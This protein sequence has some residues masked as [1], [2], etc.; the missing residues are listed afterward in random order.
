M[1]TRALAARDDALQ[2]YADE[3][4]MLTMLAGEI[5][6]ELKNPLASV[7]GLTGLL[8]KDAAG[9]RA[10]WVGVMR[11]EIER[12]QSILEEFLNFS[13]PLVPLAQGEVDLGVLCSDAA[14]L[15]EGLAAEKGV[16]IRVEIA[17]E[18][19]VRCDRRKV[20]QVLVNLLQNAIAASPQSGEIVV[21][22]DSSAVEGVAVARVVVEDRGKGLSPE[23]A[24]RLFTPGATTKSGGSGL[25]LT[26]S[27]ALARQH[28]G[29]LTLRNV[30]VGC[31]AELTLPRDAPRPPTADATNR[32]DVAP[33]PADP[34][35]TRRAYGGS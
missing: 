12:M 9:P 34:G 25:G 8:A 21:R 13:R 26:V 15:H 20:K 14:L 3:S 30:P 28:G 11:R 33:S 18:L 29:E 17:S 19:V 7:K 22:V 32:A 31:A 5:A 1:A 2:S 10:E 4:R 6:H 23:I 16:H 27:R 24:Q 35:G